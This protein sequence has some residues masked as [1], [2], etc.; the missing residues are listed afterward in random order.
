MASRVD[1]PVPMQPLYPPP[2]TINQLKA[3][4]NVKVNG[5]LPKLPSAFVIY[6][7]AYRQQLIAVHS[8]NLS[9]LLRS[10]R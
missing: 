4:Y 6:R 2:V 7:N 1:P 3:I 10:M 5:K 9:L 8:R